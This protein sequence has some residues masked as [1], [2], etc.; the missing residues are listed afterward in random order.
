MHIQWL[1]NRSHHQNHMAFGPIGN[2]LRGQG[3]VLKLLKIKPEVSQKDLSDILGMRPQSLGELLAK[4]ERGGYI[5]RTQSESDK[6]AMI[7]R[8]TEKG[9]EAG[10]QK[11]EQSCFDVLFDCF[12]EEEQASLSEYLARITH[13]LEKHFAGDRDKHR[14]RLRSGNEYDQGGCCAVHRG[15]KHGRRYRGEPIRA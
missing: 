1:F 13:E 3:R 6:R 5:T 7:I 2:P 9:A 15:H 11:T 12:S 8:L 4:L 10:D 14:R